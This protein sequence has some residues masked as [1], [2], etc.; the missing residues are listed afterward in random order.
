MARY[1]PLVWYGS[2]ILGGV[3]RPQ[4]ALSIEFSVTG[5]FARRNLI[6]VHSLFRLNTVSRSSD[7]TLADTA[8]FYDCITTPATLRNTYGLAEYCADCSLLR[9]QITYAKNHVQLVSVNSTCSCQ[10][11][12][13]G[14]FHGVVAG[15]CGSVGEFRR[16]PLGCI[17][18]Q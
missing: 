9:I 2:H 11:T 6:F 14:R 7:S 5:A 18:A 4:H 12:C 8:Q 16:L 15:S 10:R 1:W 3:L 17:A 13:Y